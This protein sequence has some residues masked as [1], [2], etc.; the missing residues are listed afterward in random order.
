MMRF[1]WLVSFAIAAT[2]AASL[3]QPATAQTR[4][5]GGVL[6]LNQ[7]R[8]LATRSTTLSGGTLANLQTDPNFASSSFQ[9]IVNDAATILDDYTV[10]NRGGYFPENRGIPRDRQLTTIEA[11]YRI[12]SLPDGNELFLYRTPT[13]NTSEYFIRTKS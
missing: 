11:V 2:L 10:V 13:Q 5:R 9:T 7:V 3:N 6:L 1:R 8:E 12:Y 4:I